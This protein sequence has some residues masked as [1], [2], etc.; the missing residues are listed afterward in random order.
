MELHKKRPAY[1]LIACVS[2]MLM[3]LVSSCQESKRKRF[4]REAREFT[5]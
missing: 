1:I 2:L 5:T 3:I 4:E